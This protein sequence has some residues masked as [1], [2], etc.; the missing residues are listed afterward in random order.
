MIFPVEYSISLSTGERVDISEYDSGRF[1]V[2]EDVVAMRP[3]LDVLQR[4]AVMSREDVESAKRGWDAAF[5]VAMRDPVAGLLKILRPDC[6]HVG[7]C[8]MADRKV[9][10]SRNVSGAKRIPPCFEHNSEGEVQRLM[11]SIVFAWT[12]KRRV[13]VVVQD[14]KALLSALSPVARP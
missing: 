6:V 4:C 2:L 11:T 9:C 1:P 12:E 3:V 13:I 8:I 14:P 10:T 7:S 5:R